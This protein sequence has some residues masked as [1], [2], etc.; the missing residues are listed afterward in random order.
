[1]TT[2]LRCAGMV[3]LL[4][5]SSGLV[6]G[7]DFTSIVKSGVAVPDSPGSTFSGVNLAGVDASGGVAF[8]GTYTQNAT[9]RSG[10][11]NY[12]NG[13]ITSLAGAST[14]GPAGESITTII[15]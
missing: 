7:G 2:R 6:W 5:M 4:G 11:Y 1:M 12:K 3:F 15:A 13:V 14:V 8:I 10:L 9:T